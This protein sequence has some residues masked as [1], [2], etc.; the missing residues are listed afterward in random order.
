LSGFTANPVLPPAV[1]TQVILDGMAG[2]YAGLAA[3]HI[4]LQVCHPKNRAAWRPIIA[5]LIVVDIGMLIGFT[6]A[7]HAEGRLLDLGKWRNEDFSNVI[8]YALITVLRII[9]AVMPTAST[10]VRKDR[11]GI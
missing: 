1:E 7:L 2:W 11:K 6:R 4:W 9:F 5:Q 10:S 3:L 8:G